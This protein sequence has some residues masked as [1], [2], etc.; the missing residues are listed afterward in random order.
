[1][2]ASQRV[3]KFTVGVT[4]GLLSLSFLQS[5]A[6][7]ASK[8]NFSYVKMDP[9]EK[10]PTSYQDRI[11]TQYGIRDHYK[12]IPEKTLTVLIAAD[13]QFRKKHPDWKSYTKN[14]VE[15]GTKD[16]KEYYNI[17]YVPAQFLDWQ[18]DGKSPG[19]ILDD[20]S[21][22]YGS[23][24]QSKMKD[25]INFSL[26]IGFT[27]NPNYG[28]VGGNAAE[29]VSL[30]PN[31]GG[32]SAIITI[33]DDDRHP[34]PITQIIK[35]EVSHT[36]SVPNDDKSLQDSVMSTLPSVG[37]NGKTFNPEW[38]VDEMFI[39][40]K[41][42]DRYPNREI[43]EVTSFNNKLKVNR[44]GN[45]FFT[46]VMSSPQANLGYV[47]GY[48]QVDIDIDKKPVADFHMLETVNDINERL[49]S[50]GMV[51]NEITFTKLFSP[52]AGAANPTDT[53]KFN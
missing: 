18:S 53:Y 42:R 6:L 21:K 36:Y 24:A 12:S 31:N 49:N 34:K 13:E 47:Y 50:L 28:E 30:S 44:T 1:M 29:L 46:E 33:N 37:P 27:D 32:E 26:V 45:L 3:K 40:H 43:K 9:D 10:N 11:D 22:D 14:L 19:E 51:G 20:L 5:P 2:I 7:A 8:V 16:F 17:K 38:S 52:N 15:E 39:I 4:I 25:T 41:Y 48:A 35:H 23:Y